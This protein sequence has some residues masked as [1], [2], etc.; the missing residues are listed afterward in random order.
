MRDENVLVHSGDLNTIG[1]TMAYL[2][3][4]INEVASNMDSIN[5]Q[6]DGFQDQI[7]DMKQNVSTLEEEVRSFM[8]EMKQN[9][10]VSNAKQSIMISQMEYE[11]KYGHRDDVRRRVV[12]LLQSVD[13]NSLKKNTMENIG[14]E[15]VVNNP[16]Y[17]LAPALVALCY[18]YGNNKKMAN[19][20]LKKAMAR[21]DEKTSL[22][23]CLVHLRAGRINT[24]IKWLY[25]YLNLQD[26]TNMDCK[27]ILLLDAL[28]SGIFD[29]E[30][31]D[32]ILNQLNDWD[33]KLNS[34][35][36]Y[37]YVQV[38]RWE[39]YFKSKDTPILLEDNYVNTFVIER[40]SV[41][42]VLH[43]SN[44]HV[45]MMDEF[46]KVMNDNNYDNHNHVDKIDKLVSMLIFDYE[47][48]ELKLKSEIEK[49]NSIINAGGKID[50]LSQ[51]NDE[52][53]LSYDKR[54]LYTHIS[55]IALDDKLEIGVNTRKMAISLSRPYIIEAYKNVA[56]LDNQTDLQ[57]LS[58][59]IDDWLG[60]TKDGSNELELRESLKKHI[61]SK[62]HSD[63][64]E[65]KLVSK[66]VWIAIGIGLVSCLLL[67]KYWIL[68][69]VVLLCIM[70]FCGFSIYNNYR[71]KQG[72]ISELNAEQST[73]DI[74]L[75]NVLA[76][77]VDYYFVYKESK[78]K[79]E[80]F[81]KYIESL[82]YMDYI[83]VT[84]DNNKRSMFIGGK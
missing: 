84:H 4:C 23:F 76:E 45:N 28:S 48:E 58:I 63:I 51:L 1:N 81:I 17:W 12:G 3:D 26:P 70:A 6:V 10:L 79:E 22:L 41:N 72:K 66:E 67:F 14:E 57:Y 7:N 64:Y 43:F 33:I 24:A 68:L 55:N 69:L 61:E 60:S 49:S 18:W 8:N 75:M 20:A 15:T 65:K 13:I 16:D 50:I 5:G 39:D 77:I 40:D 80:E 47:D 62:Y 31:K 78:I 71:Y 74:I 37:K 53:L 83:R 32:I 36:E 56:N 54:D 35:M 52:Y 82:N 21:S 59:V 34:Y 44:F 27:I 42:N 38:K 25:R 2:S 30:I 11:K 29:N 73:R 9:A 46:K 19:A